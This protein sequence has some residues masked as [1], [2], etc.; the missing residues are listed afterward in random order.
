MD[1]KLSFLLPNEASK[2]QKFYFWIFEQVKQ[3]EYSAACCGD[4]VRA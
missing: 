1:R 3:K 2:I 4:K